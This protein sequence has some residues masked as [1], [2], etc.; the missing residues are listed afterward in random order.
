MSSHLAVWDGSRLFLKRPSS[1]EEA[2]GDVAEF[3]PDREASWL[4]LDSDTYGMTFSKLAVPAEQLL[5]RPFTLPLK[6]PRLVDADLLAQELVEQLGDSAGDYWL[7]WQAESHEAGVA[8]MLFGLSWTAKQMLSNAGAIS[9]ASVIPD[10]WIRLTS[11][12]RKTG[13]DNS[14][15][16]GAVIDA[17][18][19]GLFLGVIRDGCWQGMRRLNRAEGLSSEALAE[20]LFRSLLAMGFDAAAGPV[21]GRL[22]WALADLIAERCG[23]W[24]VQVVATDELPQRHEASLNVLEY[25]GRSAI[26]FRRGRWRIRTANSGVSGWRRSAL[27]AALLAGVAIG[28]G[29]LQ[30]YIY[31]SDIEELQQGIEA[32]F[33]RGL[34]DER[35]MIDPLVQLR[36]AAPNLGDSGS[37]RVLM[38]QL[39][40]LADLKKEQP[41]WT[42]KEFRFDD[43]EFRL[44]GS[45]GDIASMNRMREWLSEK[46][47]RE[48][49][50]V[51]TQL[52]GQQISF[53]MKWS[54]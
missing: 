53:R 1:D 26:D 46:T 51:D 21:T 12:L 13:L 52:N 19:E 54:W 45:A 23:D 22:D 38:Q 31:S 48:I 3:A 44:N 39:S 41:G 8:G 15:A 34:P 5:I 7:C 20:N 2:N 40:V 43:G 25:S 24:Q 47:G 18:R 6:D 33:H 16:T 27:L 37:V 14:V 35:V 10:I 30:S 29:L 32:A 11:Q 9:E 42:M 17:D 49:M 50:I 36:A 4:R 28:S